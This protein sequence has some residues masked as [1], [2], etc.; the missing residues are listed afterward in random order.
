[1]GRNNKKFFKDLR[2]QVHEKLVS[3]Q[4]F[5]ESKRKAKED[6]TDKDKIFSFGT[7]ETYW[8]HCKYYVTWLNKTYPECTTLRSAKR[9]VNE[10]LEL[11]TNTV[12]KNGQPLSA[13]TIQTEC[14]ALC[15]LFG[16]DRSD[17]NR[18]QPPQR[19]RED[20]R[21]SRVDVKQDRHFSK[22]NNAELIDFCRGTGCRR[23]VLERL[24]GRDLWTRTM[25][26]DRAR[27]LAGKGH[28]TEREERHL[29]TIKDALRVFPEEKE[30]LH[31]RK[32]KN[33]KYRFAPIVGPKRDQIIERMRSTAFKE[34]VW[35]HVPKN[36][37]IH[38]YRA[39]YATCMYKDHAR[40]IERIPFDRVNR[41]T[42][43]RYQSDVYVCRKDEAG[44][45]LDKR[46][47]AVCSKALGHN[48]ISVIADHYLRGL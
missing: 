11:R 10:W 6:G 7:Y 40:D 13:W 29:L 17:P 22:T 3:M 4:A 8:K 35:K 45:R 34:K 46:A 14:S 18:F 19:H 38:S 28:R 43:H 27:E 41:G 20:I 9:H 21:R 15:K 48:R 5:G 12:N 32:D 16:I 23:G 31:H 30:F 44:K 37:D 24:E 42:G 25:M 39:E 26:E 36:A 2:E 1:M 47:M 33:G